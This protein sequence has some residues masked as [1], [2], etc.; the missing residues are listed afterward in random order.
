MIGRDAVCRVVLVVAAALAGACGSQ[1]SPASPSA[2]TGSVTVMVRGRVVD[3]DSDAPLAGAVVTTDSVLSNSTGRPVSPSASAA[4]DGAG[5]FTLAVSLPEAWSELSVI[6]SRQG[7]EYAF[8]SYVLRE[9]STAATASLTL[10]PTRT[11]APGQSLVLPLDTTNICGF[12]G[13]PCRRVALAAPPGTP[14]EVTLTPLSDQQSVGLSATSN[15]FVIESYRTQI[16]STTGEVWIV[17]E[18]GKVKLTAR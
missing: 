12:D 17:G 6:A 9:S 1:S 5:E 7:Y 10:Y 3:I 13:E 8:P 14:V 2:G 16:V 4:T 15:Y 11:L 18:V